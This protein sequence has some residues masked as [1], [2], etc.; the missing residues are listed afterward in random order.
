MEEEEATQQNADIV[1]PPPIE[2]PKFALRMQNRRESSSEEAL[3]DFKGLR[4]KYN[5]YGYQFYFRSSI[6]AR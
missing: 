1:P 3:K 6:L 2:K 4:K 5:L